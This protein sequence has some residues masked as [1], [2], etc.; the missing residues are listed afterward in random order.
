MGSKDV[1][2]SFGGTVRRVL[3]AFDGKAWFVRRIRLV[4]HDMDADEMIYY[5]DQPIGVRFDSSHKALAAARAF[6][7]T[8]PSESPD[9]SGATVPEPTAARQSGKTPE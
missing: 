6:L 2:A 4:E 5:C 3:V 9:A 8:P 7:R 1:G